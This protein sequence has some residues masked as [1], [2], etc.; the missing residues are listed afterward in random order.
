MY[1]ST[2]EVL[3][4]YYDKPQKYKVEDNY[5]RCGNLWGLRIDNNHKDYVIV[6]L[7]DLGSHL[8]QNEQLYWRHFN[9]PP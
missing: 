1:F 2:K 9:I 4:K 8:S 3:K 6:F 7:G 5:I